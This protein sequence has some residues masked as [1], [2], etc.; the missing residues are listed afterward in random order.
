[1]SLLLFLR[2]YPQ[3]GDHLH[4]LLLPL[5]FSRDSVNLCLFFVFN[6]HSRAAANGSPGGNNSPSENDRK[7]LR[8][9]YQT[10]TFKVELNFA[11]KI[12][13]QS[14]AMALK[15]QETENSQEALRVLDIILRQH[16][17]KQYV[18]FFFLLVV[19]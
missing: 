10:K 19:L 3:T 18:F 5:H 15:G 14:I 8:R 16:A 17:A 4:I 7:R 11:A 12:P 13:M 6:F 1:M 9:P 2:I